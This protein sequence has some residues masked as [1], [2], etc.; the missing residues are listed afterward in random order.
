MKLLVYTI[1]GQKIGIDIQTWTEPM[2]GGNPA[3]LAIP[4]T[5]STPTDYVEISSTVYWD[6]F[7]WGTTLSPAEIKN[8][9]LKLIPNEP[10]AQ[11]YEILENYMNVG[12]NSMTNID[13]N[14]S[15]TTVSIPQT[16]SGVTD[17]KLTVD[18]SG[19]VYD[20]LIFISK[21]TGSTATFSENFNI[22][23]QLNFG[24]ATQMN[25]SQEFINLRYNALFGVNYFSGLVFNNVVGDGRN[26]LMGVNDDGAMVGGWS[27]STLQPIATGST[28]TTGDTITT[29]STTNA[30][31]VTTTS[32]TDVLMS[33]MQLTSIPAGNYLL[34]FGT[35]F[36]HSSNGDQIFTNIYVGGAAVTG[37]EQHWR[38]GAAQGD[39]SSTHNYS[40]FP[41]TLGT[42]AT[43]EIRW[44]TDSATAS[45]ENPYMS[46]IKV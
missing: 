17:N 8:E 30:N 39:I 43:V 40:G 36:E 32:A 10:T 18:E 27:G 24:Y 5:G 42:T 23:G 31:T 21:I 34:S 28:V 38:R 45:G 25:T 13:D 19:E 35:S 12:I 16:L 29:Y 33:G 26:F 37:G 14:L 22:D 7:G 20:E 9:I 6:Q 1:G 11:E 44:R 46:L 4:D 3:F 15:L 41:I 2:L